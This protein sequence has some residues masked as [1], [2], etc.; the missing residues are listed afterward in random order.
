MAVALL[1]YGEGNEK[2]HFLEEAG[3][4]SRDFMLLITK[5]RFAVRFPELGCEHVV[6]AGEGIFIPHGVAFERRILEPIDYHQFA[7]AADGAHPYY[8]A[9]QAGKLAIPH[10]HMAS[11]TDSFRRA[12]ALNDQGLLLHLVEHLLAEQYL[13][14]RSKERRAP[15]IDADILA[16][17]AYMNEHLSEKMDVDELAARAYLSHTGLIWKFKRQLG[18]TPLQFLIDLRMRHAEELLLTGS[19]SVGEIAERCGYPNAYY[20]TNAFRRHAGKSPTAYRK[21]H[22]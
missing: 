7:L 5:G 1:F 8:G 19:L 22:L 10:A 17:I 3:C 14:A 13:F 9:M 12:N 4:P 18:T 20:F 11:L 15:Q 2:A 21:S 16:L 6:E